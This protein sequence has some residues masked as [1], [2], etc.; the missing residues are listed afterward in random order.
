MN[1]KNMLE[2]I[3]R[4][5]QRLAAIEADLATERSQTTRLRQEL[6]ETRRMQ[7]WYNRRGFETARQ[8]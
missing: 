8:E 1:R 6:V 2:E 4:L 3:A 5:Q 7:D